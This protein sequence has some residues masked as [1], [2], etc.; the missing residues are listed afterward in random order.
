MLTEPARD[1]HLTNLLNETRILLLGTQVFLGFLATVAFTQPFAALDRSRRFVYL[2]TFTTTLFALIL[3]VV[4]AAYHRLARPVKHKDRFKAFANWFLVA[5]L[6][7][8]SVSMILVAYLVAYVAFPD[9]AL[10]LCMG[11]A[12]L[13][14][15][16]WW[17]TPLLR[18]HDRFPGNRPLTGHATRG[19]TVDQTCFP[20]RSRRSSTS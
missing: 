18:L 2:C 19:R 13:I 9:L 11:V 15:G 17:A 3:F 5:G 1:G 10:F 4:P 14:V 12:A 20:T 8:M 16:T 6:V 7:P